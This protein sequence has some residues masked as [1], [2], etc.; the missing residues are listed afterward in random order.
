MKSQA[1]Q[2]SRKNNLIY[3]H[4]GGGVA[5]KL[6]HLCL[7]IYKERMIIMSIILTIREKLM[8]IKK[9]NW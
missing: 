5:T 1:K 7:F 3:V 6:A 4:K 9:Q 2:N 8:D